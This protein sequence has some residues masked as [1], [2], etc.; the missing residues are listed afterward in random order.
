V[1]RVRAALKTIDNVDE[2]AVDFGAKTAT[3]SASGSGVEKADCEKALSDAGYGVKSFAK[4]EA[5]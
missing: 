3:I 2:V 5:Q 4:V 1:Q